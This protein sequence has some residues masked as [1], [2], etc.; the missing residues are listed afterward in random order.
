[1]Y[2][3]AQ[4]LDQEWFHVLVQID[5]YGVVG[6]LVQ[7]LICIYVVS[8]DLICIDVVAGVLVQ[9]LIYIYVVSGVLICI[10]VVAGV[11]V[12]VLI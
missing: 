8:G 4:G 12:Q 10:D 2:V 1:M 5:I 11:S 3:L 7:V 6:V 9:V